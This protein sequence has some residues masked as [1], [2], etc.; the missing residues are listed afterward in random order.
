MSTAMAIA[1]IAG[2]TVDSRPDEMPAE[3]SRLVSVAQLAAG[4]AAEGMA[5]SRRGF[6]PP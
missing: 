1:A 5:A 6:D 2:L 4:L 3:P